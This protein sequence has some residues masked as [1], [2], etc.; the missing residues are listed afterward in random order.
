LSTP[1]VANDFEPQSGEDAGGEP[2]EVEGVHL[3]IREL[4]LV[5][6]VE[7]DQLDRVLRRRPHRASLHVLSDRSLSLPRRR[8]TDQ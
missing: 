5:R 1:C 4:E 7:H 8:V 3:G 6:D 2:L